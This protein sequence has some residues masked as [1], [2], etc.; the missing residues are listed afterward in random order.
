[1]AEGLVGCTTRST[2]AGSFSFTAG[3]PGQ[4]RG[5]PGPATS[6]ASTRLPAS[7]P[8]HGDFAGNLVG[9]LAFQVSVS[10]TGRKLS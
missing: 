9:T 3:A 4:C 8:E 2:E 1:M 5:S 10:Q 6:A 7:F